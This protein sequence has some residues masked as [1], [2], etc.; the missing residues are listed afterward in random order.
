MKDFKS[1][2]ERLEGPDPE[3]KELYDNYKEKKD[4]EELYRQENLEKGFEMLM[5]F[6]HYLW[7]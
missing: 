3:Y 1:A 6:F 7:Y 2:A 4:E 5:K